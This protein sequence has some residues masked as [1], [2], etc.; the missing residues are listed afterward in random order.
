M[1]LRCLVRHGRI[2]PI[3]SEMVGDT[4]KRRARINDNGMIVVFVEEIQGGQ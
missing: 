4:K 2:V 3:K 1:P